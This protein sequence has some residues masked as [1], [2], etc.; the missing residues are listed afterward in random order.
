MA[1]LKQPIQENKPASQRS[2]SYKEGFWNKTRPRQVLERL[3]QHEASPAMLEDISRR[4]LTDQHGDAEIRTAICCELLRNADPKTLLKR[5]AD[6]RTRFDT[7]QHEFFSAISEIEQLK[8][9]EVHRDLGYESWT[10]FSERVLGLSSQIA[11]ALI[12]AREEV[13]NINPNQFLQ[14]MI[15]GYVVPAI[16]NVEQPIKLDKLLHR[17]SD[18]ETI[19]KELKTRLEWAE[20][21]TGE[22]IRNNKA[23]NEEL[24]QTRAEKYREVQKREAVIDKL[25]RNMN[26]L[27]VK[28]S[29]DPIPNAKSVTHK[30]IRKANHAQNRAKSDKKK[31]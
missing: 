28:P 19:I 7:I 10:E 5:V 17:K 4:V 26:C 23:F 14:A 29:D 13:T 24:I 11:E 12:L 31:P 27:A 8:S 30:V 25:C 6:L 16:T 20:F 3:E 1:Q 21:K 22:L 15:K 9:W 18:P 2:P